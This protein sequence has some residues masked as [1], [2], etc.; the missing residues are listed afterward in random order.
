M[1][2]ERKRQTTACQTLNIAENSNV[3][4]KKK[5]TSEEQAHRSADSA[6]EGAQRQAEDQRKRLRETTEQLNDFKEEMAVLRAQLEEAQ[7]LEDQAGKAKAK[8]EKAKAKAEKEKD[9][10]EQ[11][12]YVVGVAR[13]EV[14]LRAKVPVVYRACCAQTWV[15]ALNWAGVE[16]S[17]ELRRP[18]NIF[19]PPAI[20]VSGLSSNQKEAIPT[21]AEPAEKAQVQNPPP[22]SQQKQAKEPEAPK[23]ISSDKAAEVPKDGIAS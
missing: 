6:L 9:K 8:V 14:A 15:E 12:G 16:A 20:R 21:V 3:E 10:A 22:P 17:S 19:F 5:L 1:E 4:L 23:V 18:E 7:R 13:I 2:D 11:H